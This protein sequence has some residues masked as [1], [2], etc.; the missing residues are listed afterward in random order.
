MCTPFFITDF[1]GEKSLSG[2]FP[3]QFG[4]RLIFS[5]AWV[6]QLTMTRIY[7]LFQRL[8]APRWTSYAEECCQQLLDNGIPSDRYAVAL[9]R[10]Q[11]VQEKVPLSLWHS[12]PGPVGAFP[13]PVSFTQSLDTQVQDLK[14][15][16]DL[17][18]TSKGR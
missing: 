4:V 8:E 16:L 13:P 11:L 15:S 3:S 1:R 10:L 2:A 14:R 17:E 9:I 12:S 18:I 5:L 6:H 7:L